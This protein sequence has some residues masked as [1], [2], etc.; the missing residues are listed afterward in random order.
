MSVLA[1]NS[2]PIELFRPGRSELGGFHVAVRVLQES[3]DGLRQRLRVMV[4]DFAGAVTQHLDCVGE[5]C[6]HNRSSET[7]RI[8]DASTYVAI[9][10]VG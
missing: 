7:D 6:R 2:Y 5:P 9:H 1:C 4:D 8:G 10:V 3:A